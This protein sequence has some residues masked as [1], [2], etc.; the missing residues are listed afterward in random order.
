MKI[1]I[2]GKDV[3]ITAD[4]KNIIDVADRAKIAIPA[5]CYRAQQSKGCCNACVVEINGEQKFACATTPE[6]GM[7]I[8]LD[9]PDLKVIRK[10]RL[11]KYQE[12]IKSGNP[13]GCNCSCSSN[14]K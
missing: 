14:K 4:D 11:L 6:D 10:E 7:D 5:P 13:C 9:R 1:T 3:D 8:V 2:D 12:G